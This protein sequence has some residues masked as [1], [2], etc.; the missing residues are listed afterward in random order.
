M[1]LTQDDLRV[2]LRPC[3]P[4]CRDGDGHP[5]EHPDDRS[6]WSSFNPVPLTMHPA[7]RFGPQEYLYAAVDVFLQRRPEA[8]S[9]V[10]MLHNEADDREMTMTLDEAVMLRDAITALLETAERA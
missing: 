4:W 9:P 1:T 8:D 6:C 2:P 3:A 10:L 5:G 7:V